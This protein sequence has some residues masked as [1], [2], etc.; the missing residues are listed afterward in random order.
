MLVRSLPHA[1]VPRS[2][3]G[4]MFPFQRLRSN[5]AG[6][7][8][9]TAS[10]CTL[11]LQSSWRRAARSLHEVDEDETAHRPGRIQRAVQHPGSA[12]SRSHRP[13]VP[14]DPVSSC[15]CGFSSRLQLRCCDVCEP[16]EKWKKDI[17]DLSRGR[18]ALR[19]LT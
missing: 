5:F 13:P 4:L 19:S 8:S 15:L 10:P 1:L 3:Q 18:F 17:G 6:L 11:R 12:F 9:T 2:P 7:S 16:S 14:R